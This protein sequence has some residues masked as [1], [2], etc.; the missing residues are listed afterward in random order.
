M[1]TNTR[2]IGRA[3]FLTAASPDLISAGGLSHAACFTRISR[4]TGRARL[5]PRRER[6]RVSTPLGAPQWSTLGTPV[7]TPR[8]TG[9][10][11]HRSASAP[12]ERT[13]SFGTN[14]QRRPADRHV[15]VIS[16]RARCNAACNDVQHAVRS[17]NPCNVRHAMQRATCKP[18]PMQRALMQH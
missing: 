12:N 15:P 9:T 17:M 11:A 10:R 13:I 8:R 1:K 14:G 5:A 18:A 4:G 7:S 6:G 3:C 2:R 16:A